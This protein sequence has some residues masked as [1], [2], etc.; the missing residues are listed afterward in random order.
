[1]DQGEVAALSFNAG[2]D[3]TRSQNI[4]VPVPGGRQSTLLCPP[5]LSPGGDRLAWLV[6]VAHVPL[7]WPAT[8]RFWSACHVAPIVEAGLWT[9]RPDGSDP[10]EVGECP[11]RS[12]DDQPTMLQ[13]TPD[14]RDLTFR[15]EGALYSIPAR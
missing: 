5:V 14:G 2:S 15:H 11:T 4:R 6:S 1:V 8:R 12:Q 9:T 10:L 13:W 3:D 7:G